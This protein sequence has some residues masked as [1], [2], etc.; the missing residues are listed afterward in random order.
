MIRFVVSPQ[1]KVVPDVGRRLPGRGM[2][3]LAR[4]DAVNRAVSDNLFSRAAR[5][6]V[7]CPDRLAD[8]VDELLRDRLCHHIALSRKAGMAFFGFERI[9]TMI[10][11][12]ETCSLLLAIDGS[13]RQLEKTFP[14]HDFPLF[15]RSLYGKELGLAFDRNFVVHA[16][17]KRGQLAKTISEESRRLRSYRQLGED[18]ELANLRQV[19]LGS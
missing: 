3:L 19:R 8:T 7:R 1:A 11:S 13:M 9:R 12:G 17:V 18:Y 2:W 10:A 14:A 5:Q 4:H 15:S 6:A 16:A